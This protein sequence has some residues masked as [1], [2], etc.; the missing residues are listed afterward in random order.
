M[1]YRIVRK[2]GQIR[3]VQEL[4]RN[5]VGT[6]EKPVWVQGAVYDVTPRKHVEQ[7]LQQANSRLSQ[8]LM[9]TEEH[10]QEIVLLQEMGDLFQTCQT[11]EET[12][13]V[14]EQYIV[15]MFPEIIRGFIFLSKERLFP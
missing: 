1:E 6:D 8:S 11:T 7:E 2:D 10:N 13:Q 14:F 9:E 4:V 3:W 15:Q 12:C 5:V